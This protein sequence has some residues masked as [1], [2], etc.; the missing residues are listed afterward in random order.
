MH[1]RDYETFTASDYHE[2]VLKAFDVNCI[3][4]NIDLELSELEEQSGP[5]L[6]EGWAHQFGGRVVP[7]GRSVEGNVELFWVKR[8]SPLLLLRNYGGD[9]NFHS[10]ELI[11]HICGVEMDNDS[12]MRTLLVLTTSRCVPRKVDRRADKSDRLGIPID[13]LNFDLLSKQF[14]RRPLVG[15]PWKR[16]QGIQTPDMKGPSGPVR[17]KYDW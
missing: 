8:P 16:I 11:S 4:W 5:E 12:A 17:P 7:V 14:P 2:G 1:F 10:V 9:E 15:K 6:L 13:L 3:N